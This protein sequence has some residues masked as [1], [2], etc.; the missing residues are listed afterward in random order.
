MRTHLFVP[1][2]LIVI[3]IGLVSGCGPGGSQRPPPPTR[4]ESETTDTQAAVNPPAAAVTSGDNPHPVTPETSS[5]SPKSNATDVVLVDA[6]WPELLALIE[7]HPGK[8]IVVDIWSTACEPC[9][10]EFPS[11]I[12]LQQRFPDDVV[13][14][15]FDVDYAGMKNKPPAYYRERVLAFLASQ[16][17]NQVLHRMCTEPAE[18]FFNSIQLDSIPAVFVYGRDGKL[19][20]RFE[21]SSGESAGVSYEKQVIP[22]VGDQV[23]TR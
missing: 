7:Q 10:K 5:D 17:E 8:I 1:T 6:T 18:E 3:V 11:L 23:K 15:S 12:E 21:G 22:F 4:P 14:I 2:F 9:M 13:G 20:K 16:Q 19:L